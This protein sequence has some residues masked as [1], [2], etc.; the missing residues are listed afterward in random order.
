VTDA[1]PTVHLRS[2]ALLAHAG[3]ARALAARLVHDGSAADD[4]VQDAFFA[5]ICRP[6]QAGRPL[7]PWLAAVLRNLA[8]ARR[9]GDGRRARRERLVAEVSAGAADCSA[10]D[11]AARLDA[12]RVLAE[13][14]ASLPEPLRETVYL[15]YYEEL[16]STEI[17]ARTGVPAATVRWRLAKALDV[18][19][20]RLDARPGGRDRWLAALTPLAL[21]YLA[22]RS[23]SA[24]TAVRSA[25]A[26]TGVLV[27]GTTTKIVVG[28]V[29]VALL[30][31]ALVATHVVELGA[32]TR[33]A[34]A[35]VEVAFRPERS[36]RP[37]PQPKTPRRRVAAEE[38]P[39][40]VGATTPPNAV[41]TKVASLAVRARLLDVDGAPIASGRIALLDAPA[42]GA[43]AGAD[44]RLAFA[45][46]MDVDA[47]KSELGFVASAPRCATRVVA[48]GRP[49]GGVLDLGD[50]ALA[51]GG[52][53]VGR[54]VDVAGAPIAGV[55][56][57]VMTESRD[58]VTLV[59]RR[60]GRDDRP[61]RRVRA[62]GRAGRERPALGGQGRLRVPLRPGRGPRGP[63]ELRSRRR[64]DPHRSRDARARCRP[65]AGRDARAA[66]CRLVPQRGF[67]RSERGD[68]VHGRLGPIRHRRERRQDVEALGARS[69]RTLVAS[70]D[71]GRP[72]GR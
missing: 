55:T 48:A 60:A 15:R 41:E 6:P 68:L 29:A 46:G 5:A 38:T 23:G 2:E 59:V 54:I 21:P 67:R 27:M 57:T 32:T 14:V 63:G 64:V 20:E 4:L 28:V 26:L 34:D 31:G 52:T 19:R 49:A 45:L 25:A 33:V 30:F 58:G 53:V 7:R 66:R 12:H 13:V 18:L 35:P 10:A 70:I 22:P 65:R 62:G 24:R 40:P 51:S 72:F 17:A 50:V 44:G 43:D 56:I 47:S 9:R 8:L 71:R 3:W 11:V 36:E 16:D 61:G 69:R 39:S 42:V 37:E 1:G